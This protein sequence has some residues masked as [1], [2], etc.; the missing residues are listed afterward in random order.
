MF[1][2]RL[3]HSELVL[4]PAGTPVPKSI[5]PEPAPGWKSV[6]DTNLGSV[7]TMVPNFEMA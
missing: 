6:A 1:T 7:L 4:M 3:A 5:A 2:D